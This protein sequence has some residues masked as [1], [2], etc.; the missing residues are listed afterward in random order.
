MTKS[1]ELITN[2]TNNDCWIRLLHESVQSAS[3]KRRQPEVGM[4]VRAR[5]SEREAPKIN[6]L[7]NVTRQRVV[8]L[9]CVSHLCCASVGVEE[10]AASMNSRAYTLCAFFD[11]RMRFDELNRSS[12]EAHFVFSKR[13]WLLQGDCVPCAVLDCRVGWQ[14]TFTVTV[15]KCTRTNEHND[16][17]TAQ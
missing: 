2:R 15:A 5:E 10:E 9:S 8:L 3:N 11:R 13:L 7:E 17:P 4:G 14:H 12:L 6:F 1:A 16:M